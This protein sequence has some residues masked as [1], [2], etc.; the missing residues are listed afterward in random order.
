[1]IWGRSHRKHP[2]A[3]VDNSIVHKGKTEANQVSINTRNKMVNTICVFYHEL[4]SASRGRGPRKSCI[5]DEKK[6]PTFKRGNTVQN[7]SDSQ[8]SS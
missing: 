1:M 3:R 7:S 4:T 8:V 5:P 2:C 6:L